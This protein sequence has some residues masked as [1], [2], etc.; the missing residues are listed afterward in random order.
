MFYVT[1]KQRH[2]RRQWEWQRAM[3]SWTIKQPIELTITR[4]PGLFRFNLTHKTLT[5][6]N[7]KTSKENSRALFLFY[8]SSR[9]SLLSTH[10]LIT[11]FGS[12]SPNLVVLINVTKLWGVGLVNLSYNGFDYQ[13]NKV[14]ARASR[15]LTFLWRHCTTTVWNFVISCFVKKVNTR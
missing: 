8:V 6:L 10:V 12:P 5:K 13:N 14:F 9:S 4:F 3:V 2:W 11:L 1:G 7:E 15:F